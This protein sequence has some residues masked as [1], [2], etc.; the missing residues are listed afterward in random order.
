MQ[1]YKLWRYPDALLF[2]KLKDNVIN[3]EQPMS[4]NWFRSAFRAALRISGVDPNGFGTHSLRAGGATDLF[5][6]GVS[7]P[8]IKKYGRW[9]TDTALIYYRDTDAVVEEVF[10][11][12]KRI[13]KKS[14]LL[15]Y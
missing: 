5:K 3:P 11:G 9:K 12:F 15:N 7:Y 10:Q 2:P 1:Y 4:V 8:N 6:A 14:N 13:A